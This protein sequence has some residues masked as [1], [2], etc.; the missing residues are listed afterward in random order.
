M[1]VIGP[2]LTK[3]QIEKSF[4][5]CVPHKTIWFVKLKLLWN[6]SQEV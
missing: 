1:V 6:H 4:G 5:E 2:Q 3:Y